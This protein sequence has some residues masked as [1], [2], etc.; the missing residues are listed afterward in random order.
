MYN[1]IDITE[2]QIVYH[3]TLY[4]LKQLKGTVSKGSGYKLFSG[5]MCMAESESGVWI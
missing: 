1:T 2:Y 4:S 5:D 3:N